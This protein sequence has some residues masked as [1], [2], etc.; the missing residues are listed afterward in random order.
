[1]NKSLQQLFLILVM[2]CISFSMQAQGCPAYEPNEVSINET[3]GHV[4][5]PGQFMITI[6]HPEHGSFVSHGTNSIG[7]AP[8]WFVASPYGFVKTSLFRKCWIEEDGQRIIILA[9][10]LD[11]I[12]DPLS[13]V[14]VGDEH[15]ELVG[16]CSDLEDTFME[17]I[18]YEDKVGNVYKVKA[19]CA[20]QI[21]MSGIA[22]YCELGNSDIDEG[23]ADYE[24]LCNLDFVEFFNSLDDE[25]P[26]VTSEAYSEPYL[27]GDLNGA[28]DEYNP[29]S[30]ESATNLTE[31]WNT[32]SAFAI[33]LQEMNEE[34]EDHCSE[35][36]TVAYS[37]PF[38]QGKLDNANPLNQVVSSTVF[39]NP[40][41][42]DFSLQL[43]TEV[44]DNYTVSVSDIAGRII[45]QTNIDIDS[46][47][48]VDLPLGTAP[49][50][51]YFYSISNESHIIGKGK[52]IKL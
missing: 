5:A 4:S 37:N 25:K 1:M 42:G 12:K 38:E 15:Y 22:N 14:P 50:G 51:V 7:V 19:Q 49:M 34:I 6:D 3:T 21:L 30:S 11:I 8:H 16:L 48:I 39:P 32:N 26:F 9:E 43:S 29:E 44:A 31:Y 36:Y 40:S 17:A 35:L 20:C 46:P 24:S 45:Y 2:L 27:G 52:M 33:V 47:V 13:V 18:T 28:I 23:D 10:S 41:A